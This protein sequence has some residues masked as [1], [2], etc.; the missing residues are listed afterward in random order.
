M[1]T[2]RNTSHPD[3]TLTLDL[4]ASGA[5]AARSAYARWPPYAH[6][7]S[8]THPRCRV[9]PIGSAE[10]RKRTR[11]SYAN[12]AAGCP[13]LCVV[14]RDHASSRPCGL[15]PRIAAFRRPAAL[16]P[17]ST[18]PSTRPGPELRTEACSVRTTPRLTKFS[19]RRFT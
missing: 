6:T 1:A 8:P 10:V 3:R 7:T 14:P 19:P 15:R 17:A 18:H 11:W 5:L 2:T 12:L 16:I 13:H 9:F 4:R